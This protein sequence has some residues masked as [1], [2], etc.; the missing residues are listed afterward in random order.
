MIISRSEIKSLATGKD[1]VLG[2][3]KLIKNLIKDIED[4]NN[5]DFYHPNS[6]LKNTRQ[7]LTR[8]TAITDDMFEDLL[9]KFDED[10]FETF[11][12]K[13]NY[14][15]QSI[16]QLRK[17]GTNQR[18]RLYELTQPYAQP[19]E[20]LDKESNTCYKLSV[21]DMKN[22][23]WI[24]KDSYSTPKSLT[25]RI[26]RLCEQI[27]KITDINL[28]VTPIK[29]SGKTTEYQF[30]SEFKK[31]KNST[32]KIESTKTIDSKPTS[33]RQQLTIWGVGKKQIDTWLA[34][35]GKKQST[36]QSSKRS[37][38]QNVEARHLM[39]ADIFIQYWVNGKQLQLT[40]QIKADEVLD[41][42][43]KFG[44]SAADIKSAQ[45]KLNKYN[46]ALTAV[47]NK[48]LR[49]LSNDAADTEDMRQFFI[50]QLDEI[51]H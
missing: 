4:H 43:K 48:C 12:T 27:S 47:V 28:T 3:N 2:I 20:K 42:L 35:L 17:C 24:D 40:T 25:L 9:I 30:H 5:F 18:T 21:Q 44:L 51:M 26:K 34:N 10:L 15:I 29:I 33:I 23:L 32:K 11:T 39:L 37:T 31:Q 36:M 22:N 6:G 45:E 7:V 14:S 19:Y 41:C 50:D 8:R 49:E 38:V 46:G 1:S 13:K 16:E